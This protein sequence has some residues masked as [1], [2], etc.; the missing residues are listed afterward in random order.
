LTGHEE[1]FYSFS[2]FHTLALLASFARRRRGGD[3]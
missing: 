2:G 3:S 1:G